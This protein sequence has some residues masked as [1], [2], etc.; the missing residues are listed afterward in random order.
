MVGVSA[1]P[2]GIAIAHNS[3]NGDGHAHLHACDFLPA[4]DFSS[5]SEALAEAV[6]EFGLQGLDANFVLAPQQYSVLMI[7]APQ[8][9]DDEMSQAVKWRIKDLIS[10]N[11][12][13]ASVDVIPL[14]EDA[15]KNRARMVYVVATEKSTIAQVEELVSGADLTLRFV[16]VAET[17]VNNLLRYLELGHQGL[18]L[19]YLGEQEGVIN[20]GHDKDLYLTRRLKAHRETL[21]DP[22][23]VHTETFQHLLLETQRSLDYYEAQLGQP[24]ATQLWL[25]PLA[26][27]AMHLANDFGSN[28]GLQAEIINFEDCIAGAEGMSREMQEKCVVAISA[29]LRPQ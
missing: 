6:R 22:T 27:E 11:A 4:T 29:S 28:L 14:P 8:V 23:V 21:T 9:P 1:T 20:V 7:E 2:A 3:A 26:Q 15:F 16:D 17:A 13:D 19:M 5:P 12:E 18:A 25:T 10:F 24:H